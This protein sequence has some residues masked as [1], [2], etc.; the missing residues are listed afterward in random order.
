MNKESKECKEILGL[1][2]KRVSKDHAGSVIVGPKAQKD[3]QGPKAQK[4]LQ[5][6]LASKAQQVLKEFK[7]R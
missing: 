2:G 3:L 6:Q 1:R 4:E 5:G 7:E